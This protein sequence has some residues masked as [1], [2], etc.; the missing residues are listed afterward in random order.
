MTDWSVLNVDRM[1]P[2]RVNREQ[3]RETIL[4]AAMRVFARQSVYDFKMIDIAQEA[5]VGKG[6]IYEYFETKE[7]LIRG[8]VALFMQDM[9]TYVAPDG[10]APTGPE[11]ELRRFVERIFEFFSQ[12][13]SRLQLIFDMWS[14]THRSLKQA[15][16]SFGMGHYSEARDLLAAIITRGVET[17]TF[18]KVNAAHAAALILAAV[19][20]LLFQ[21]ALG[22]SNIADRKFVNN[23]TEIL[24]RG[25]LK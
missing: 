22:L 21:A 1:S 7:S 10:S 3:K 25:L 15:P 23:A 16:D 13:P 5:E 11:A 2:K 4:R 6:T 14:V 20:G 12:E 8:C 17:G 9:V 24:M 19:D 18:R